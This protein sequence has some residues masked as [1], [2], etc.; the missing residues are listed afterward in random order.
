MIATATPP[1]TSSVGSQVAH[2]KWLISLIIF[3]RLSGDL[4]T[5]RDYFAVIADNDPQSMAA[6][7]RRGDEKSR[8][9]KVGRAKP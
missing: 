3:E 4:R 2:P 9:Q 6:N 5:R 7:G 8:S 1:L